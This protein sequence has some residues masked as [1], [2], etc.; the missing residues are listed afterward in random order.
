MDFFQKGLTPPPDFW[1]F[2]DL[3]LYADFFPGTFGAIFVL[4]FTKI[5]GAQKV[6]Q[7]FWIASDPPPPFWKKSIIKLHFFLRS[8]LSISDGD[9]VSKRL[10]IKPTN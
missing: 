1:K 3:F 6:S 7:N 9:S 5:V 8:S 2:W 10:Q 4:Y